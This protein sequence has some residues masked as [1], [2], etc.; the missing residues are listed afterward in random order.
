MKSSGLSMTSRGLSGGSRASSKDKHSP[1]I[2]RQEECAVCI[3]GSGADLQPS[4]W[5]PCCQSV[6]Q[7]WLLQGRPHTR[8]P[9]MPPVQRS[10]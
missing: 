4:S 1:V 2:S 7:G 6:I 10:R 5:L 8:L 3:I 9:S